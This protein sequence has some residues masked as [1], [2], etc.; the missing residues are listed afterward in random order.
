MNQQPPLSR[1]LNTQAHLINGEHQL[2]DE[3]LDV[4]NPA[5]GQ[6]LTRVTAGGEKEVDAAV[7]AARSVLPG[8]SAIAHD[9]RTR[10]MLSYAQ[11]IEDHSEQFTQLSVADGGLT[12][13]IGESTAMFSAMF[14]RYYAGWCSKITGQ[15]LPSAALGKPPA[16][17]LAYT[18]KEP[19]GVVGAITPWNYPFGMEML[20]IAPVL[21]T[22]CT[23]VLKPAEEAPV[24]GL[25]LAELAL[26]AGIPPGVFNVVNGTGVDAGAAL[27][28]HPGV[29]KI[30]FTGSTEVGR[31]I[32]EAS[33]G[34]LKKV[35]L[36]LGGKSANIITKNVYSFIFKKQFF[37]KNLKKFNLHCT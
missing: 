10:L 28:A 7:A 33:A 4:L 15:T 30:A 27:A 19:I 25:L 12:H 16:D 20:K 6:L 5:D 2:S 17:L 8:W 14:L 36:E 18:L 11:L 29:D 1:L 35:S 24:A 22:G 3:S 21:A 34:N 37:L 9:E 32:V 23:L 26:E 31:L 13:M